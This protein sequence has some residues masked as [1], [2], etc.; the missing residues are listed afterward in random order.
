MNIAM[1]RGEIHLALSPL[2]WENVRIR[3]RLPRYP[4]RSVSPRARAVVL[5]ALIAAVS[6]GVVVAIAARSGG[7]PPPQRQAKTRPG[8]PPLVLDLGVRADPEARALRRAVTLYQGGSAAE[9]VAIFARYSSLEAK[10]GRD[11]AAW[12]DGTVDG[13]A[14]LAQLYP[15]SALVQLELGLAELWAALPGAEE[16]WRQAAVLQPDTS[17]AVTAGNLLYPQYARNLPTFVPARSTWLDALSEKPPAQQLQTVRT[18]ATRGIGKGGDTVTGRLLYGVVL[19]RLGRPVSARREYDRA[20]ALAPNNAEA[21]TAAAVAR[22]DKADPSA[23]F[24]RLGPLSR[25]FPRSATVRFHLGLMLLWI[26][27][28]GQAKKELRLATTVE[29]RSPLAAEAARYLATLRRIGK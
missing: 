27:S 19:Q 14:R 12:P 10:V 1:R 13:L 17:Y 24:S 8:S 4:R 7:E 3:A 6:A 11:V 22:F 9:A 15:K 20:V 26:G 5:T 29:P 28:V 16:A 25:R 23:A 2:V 21:L 18:W